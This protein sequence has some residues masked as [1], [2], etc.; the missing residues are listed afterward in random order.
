MSRTTEIRAALVAR[1][2]AAS[3]GAAVAASSIAWENKKFNPVTGTRYYRATFLPGEP[4]AVGI[5]ETAPDR[6]S[7]IFQIDVFESAD[8]GDGPAAIE[9]ERIAACYKRDTALVYSGVTVR[10]VKAYRS[11]GNS[12][13]PAWFMVSVV[14]VW[15]ADVAS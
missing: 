13:D 2:V 10:C 14:V 5:G 6:Y 3:P 12:D 15:T 1:L 11:P 8:K 4:F 7:G 9:A